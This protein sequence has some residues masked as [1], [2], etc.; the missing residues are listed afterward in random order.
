VSWTVWCDGSGHAQGGP[1]GVGYVAC[2]DKG[3]PAEGMLQLA[4]ATNQQ[5]EILAAAYALTQIP[6]GGTVKLVSDSQYLVEGMNDWLPKAVARDWETAGGNPVANRQHWERLLVAVKRHDSVVFE[7][8]K[9]HSTSPGNIRADCLAYA[10]RQL[11]L[12]HAA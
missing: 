9:G 11:A 2:T 6:E 12:H 1:G 4:N 8:V 7:W 10:A 5:A 3:P